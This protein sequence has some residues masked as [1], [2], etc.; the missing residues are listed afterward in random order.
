MCPVFDGMMRLIFQSRR[1]AA[2]KFLYLIAYTIVMGVISTSMECRN[3]FTPILSFSQSRTFG[4]I[5]WEKWSLSFQEIGLN[6]QKKI[7]VTRVL[8]GAL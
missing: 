5:S 1:I 3:T 8:E 6:L 7:R 2:K 4:R